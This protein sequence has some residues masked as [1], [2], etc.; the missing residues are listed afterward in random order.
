MIVNSHVLN[1]VRE[2]D[3]I[4]TVVKAKQNVP[5]STVL[6]NAITWLVRSKLV[7]AAYLGGGK[8]R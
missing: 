6:E 7:A 3:K 4:G 8:G 5:I 2:S 1:I